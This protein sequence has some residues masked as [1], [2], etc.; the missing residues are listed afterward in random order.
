MC[1]IT[2]PSKFKCAIVLASANAVMKMENHN[3]ENR[4]L[5]IYQLLTLLYIQNICSHHIKKYRFDYI[6]KIFIYNLKQT[7]SRY[8]TRGKY[9]TFL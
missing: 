9:K 3:E 5:V 8:D 7:V 4:R 2:K 6:L 1:N